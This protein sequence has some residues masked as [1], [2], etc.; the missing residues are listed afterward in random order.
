M[1]FLKIKT[2]FLLKDTF[3]EMEG[4]TQNGKNIFNIFIL[5][6]TWSSHR[7][8]VET[9]PTRNHEIAGSIP[10]LASMG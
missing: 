10:G 6:R 4:K 8:T 2:V 9:N 7:G 3:K 5:K 1:D